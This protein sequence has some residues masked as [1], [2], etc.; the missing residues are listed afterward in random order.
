MRLDRVAAA[1]SIFART[2]A[3][4]GKNHG[5]NRQKLAISLVRKTG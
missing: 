4:T 5:K 1:K 3:K 2:V